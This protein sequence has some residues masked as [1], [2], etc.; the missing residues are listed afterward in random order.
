MRELLATGYTANR[1]RQ[2]SVSMLV[3]DLKQDWRLGAEL[4]QW[5][6]VDH[7]VAS[8]WGNWR[9]FAG[10]GCDPKQRYYRSISQ[11]LRYDRDAVFVHLWLPCLQDLPA[12]E[13]HFAALPGH[14]PPGWPEP[15]VDPLSHIAFSDKWLVGPRGKQ[16]YEVHDQTRKGSGARKGSGKRFGTR[17]S[18]KGIGTIRRDA[19]AVMDNV[20][21]CRSPGSG[22]VAA[23]QFAAGRPK[24]RRW[25]ARAVPDGVMGG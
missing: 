20:V 16:E 13:A 24:A 11:G 14:R 10:V 15:I 4:F 2:I 6:L 21:A 23:E 17:C 22:S 19:P 3:R 18:G 5:L 7:D 8:N 9:Y 12:Q 1:C 25:K